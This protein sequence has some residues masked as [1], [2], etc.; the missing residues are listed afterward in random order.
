MSNQYTFGTAQSTQPQLITSQPITSN[1][2]GTVQNQLTQA[3]LLAAQYQQSQQQ[4]QQISNLSNQYLQSQLSTQYLQQ[5]GQNQTSQLGDYTSTLNSSAQY[6]AYLQTLQQ[7]ASAVTNTSTSST[8]TS[9]SSTS[10][11]SSTSS[12]SNT[13]NT[14]SLWMGDLDPW[15]NETFIFSLFAH[16][17]D[18]ANVKIIRDK[19]TGYSL[20]YGFLYFNSPQTAQYVLE[21]F[22][23]QSIPGTNRFFRLNYAAYGMGSQK[24]N[25]SQ[26]IFVGDLAPDVNDYYLQ[27]TFQYYYP[28]VY[29]AR[30]VCDP[31][32]GFSK[33]YGFVYFND[34]NERQRALTEM[35]GFPIS[36]KP[37]KVNIATK[38]NQSGTSSSSSSQS[39]SYQPPYQQ[40]QSQTLGPADPNNT[41]V[42]VGGIDPSVTHD[43]LRG[44]FSQFGEITGIKIP[45]GKGCG[46][47]EF[48][49]HEAAAKVLQELNGSAIIG[50]SQVRLSW[51][52]PT[53]KQSTQESTSNEESQYYD[54]EE[55]QDSQDTQDPQD[56]QENE[57]STQ[58]QNGNAQEPNNNIENSKSN[59]DNTE[60]K[61]KENENE[62]STNQIE[63]QNETK[64]STK[65][66]SPS[67]QQNS[68]V[69]ENQKEDESSTENGQ[70]TKDS[71][72]NL[73]NQSESSDQQP[74]KKRKTE[75]S[76]SESV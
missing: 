69:S 30:V 76:T 63:Q 10:T 39:S 40:Q 50:N 4:Q 2:T 25:E 65:E 57:D 66:N 38:K 58:L 37:I 41:T 49:S 33:G 15:M 72:E 47:V 52:R 45:T 11:S 12:G 21:T 1:T 35:Q 24:R 75:E 74:L 56:T 19:Q 27:T 67:E 32:T 68:Q 16:T 53:L 70:E 73:T 28:S 18:L 55:Y 62:E 42:F 14:N 46:F 22:N 48:A 61:Q 31:Q 43:V 3:Q 51:G 17:G 13:T 71:N 29:S 6:A 20:G 9:T 26:A 7:Y 5:Y 34:D 59:Q 64:K 23:G 44:A 60:F 8:S 54:Q 36:Y